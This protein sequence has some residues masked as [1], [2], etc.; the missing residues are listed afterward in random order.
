MISA[1]RESP[2]LGSGAGPRALL[3]GLLAVGAIAIA[4]TA[5]HAAQNTCNAQLSIDY[6][7]GP[8]FPNPGDV[9]RVRLTIGTASIQKSWATKVMPAS[10]PPVAL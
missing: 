5:T 6:V 8:N 1:G 3:L 2:T 4:P 10:R 7:S 9:V